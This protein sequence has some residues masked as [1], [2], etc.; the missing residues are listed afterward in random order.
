MATGQLTGV[1]RNLRRAMLVP[2]GARMTDGQLLRDYLRRRDEA[3]LTTLV[4]RHAP[5]VWGVCCRVLAD[6]HDAEDAFQATFLVLVRRAASIA[7]P[8][9]LANWLYGVA[10]QTATKARATVARRKVRERQVADMPEPAAAEQ[11]LWNDLRPLLDEELSHLP[12]TY[13]VVL[14]LC[15][16]EGQTRTEVA[17][18]LGL[19]E[20]TV[21][22]RLARGRALL[23]KRL[24]RRGLAVSG[25][26]LAAVLV[27]NAALAGVPNS[28]VAG[29][30]G[31]ARFVAAGQLATTGPVSVKVAALAEGVLK[32]ML[33]TKLKAVV[34]VVLLLGFIAA[35]ATALSGRVASA[36]GNQPPA[37][38]QKVNAPPRPEPELDRPGTALPDL[39]GTW[40]G[41]DWGTVVLRAAKAGEFEG[42]YTDTF[43]KDTGRIAIRWSAA[44][45]RYEGTWSEGTYRFG[46][47]A[48]DAPK[49]GAVSGAY[50]TD[51]KCEHLPGV[52]GL[53]SLRWSKK[54]KKDEEKEPFTVWGKEIN[55]L[56]AGLGFPAGP[57]RTYHT[58]ETVT[59]V[60]RVRNV[61]KK[62]VKFEYLRQFLD[63]NPPTVTDAAGKTVPQ[64][65]LTVLGQHGPVEVTLEPGKEIELESRMAGGARLAGASGLRF[66]L[67][68]DL[69][70]GKVSIQYERVLGNSSSGFIKIDPAL[71]KL[72]TGKLELDVRE[73]KTPEKP[74]QEQEAVTVWG[75]EVDGLQA[76]L[77]LTGTDTYR[78]GESVKL[79]V[80]LRNV[81]K[82]EVKVT[83]GLLREWPPS[84]TDAAGVRMTVAM[85]PHK[86]YK[87]RLTELVLKPGET[88][89][90]YN[91]VIA[92]ESTEMLR[93]FGELH[94]DTPTMYVS[95]GKYKVAFGGMVQ[96][97]PALTTGTV[98]IAVQ[99]PT[100]PAAAARES[101]TAWG[102]ELNGLQAGLGYR[103]GEKRSYHHGETVGLVLRVRNVGKEGV[104]FVYFNEFF[105]ENPPTVT[106]CAGKTIPLEGSGLEGLARPVEVNLAPGKEIDLC[107]LNLALRSASETDKARPW[108]LSGTGKFQLQF[109]RVGGNIGT[110][111]IKFDPVL[112][113]LVTGK[114]DLEVTSDPPPAAPEKK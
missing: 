106:D 36:R 13:R 94:V 82:A 1:I 114:L 33:M 89:T 59:L 84:V 97:H 45:R 74:A 93:L 62:T 95:P 21:G 10:H 54:Q 88:I 9:S 48:L 56:Q 29:A 47:I 42:T 43:G 37:T 66:G 69:G 41:D 75:K 18:R 31:V 64:A 23:A 105:Y 111:G 108:T 99:E 81:G 103:P 104:K 113:K 79:D 83:H 72:A 57:M 101:F 78:P 61:G 67:G 51:P 16:L 32:A 22:S 6:S 17:H 110:G 60:V 52:P 27:Q 28:V 34:A 40:Q 7:A 11:D 65:R 107:E 70:T 35:G 71:S 3:A 53:A 58:G 96:S 46:R 76:G 12:D 26:A 112:S 25:G 24:S 77:T 20:G 19:P 39:S 44:S 30:I 90:L 2:E 4:Q 49:D 100:K 86:L 8:E 55:G 109:E 87:V 5:M 14:V 15:D 73:A 92:V 91:P 102:K 80:K 98:E 50:T 63:E 68:P 38:E 85:P